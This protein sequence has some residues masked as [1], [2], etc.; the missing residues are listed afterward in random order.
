MKNQKY[1]AKLAATPLLIV[2]VGMGAV[3]LLLGLYHNQTSPPEGSVVD[4]AQPQAKEEFVAENK[5]AES[6]LQ[7]VPEAPNLYVSDKK[8]DE[9]V[10]KEGDKIQVLP[11]RRYAITL[12]PNDPTP[13]QWY[14]DKIS[15][16]FA[17]DSTTGGS[18]VKI[19]VIDTGFALSHEDM[20]SR[21]ATNS[22][23]SGGGKET[24][25]LDDD[26]N[27]KVDDWR[28]WDFAQSDNNPN[29]GSTNPSSSSAA[30][31]TITSGLV[32]ATGNNGIG[33]ASVNWGAKILPVQ[34]LSD[35]G[36]GYTEDVALAIRYAV[37]QGAHIISMSLGT[38]ATDPYVE[39]ALNYA[40]ANNVLVLAAAGN[41]GCNCVL[42][43]ARYPAVIAVGAT[44]STD[45]RASFSSYGSSLDIMAPGS[46]SIRAPAWS[47]GNQTTAY[48]NNIS[49]TSISTPIVA[50]AAGLVKT[51]NPSMTP[52]QL[53]AALVENADKLAG[54]GGQS[55]TDAYGYGRL[56]ARASISNYRWQLVS[57]NHSLS[58]ALMDPGETQTI[59]VI[60]KNTGTA[61]W[62][63]NGSWP[64]KLGVWGSNST[65]HSSWP[66][67]DRA[68]NLLE[69]SVAPG[70]NGTF[71]FTVRGPYGGEFFERMNLVAEGMQW[72]N[73]PG[74]L[75]YLNVRGQFRW[76]EVYH[77]HS[78]NSAVNTAGTTITLTLKAR[79][80]GNITWKKAGDFPVRL[81]TSRPFNRGTNFF[82][83]DSWLSDTR[84]VGL[85]EDSVPPGG[86]GTFTFQAKMHP[87]PGEYF[88]YFNLVADGYSWF[89]DPGANWY[90]RIP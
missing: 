11:R 83:A 53:T 42:Y 62:S 41:D 61:T 45:N 76:E 23:E 15:A 75:Y 36:T 24:N 27:G 79:N 80:T 33:V 43:P 89:N 57:L 18:S 88:E 40:S 10:V 71:V 38:N 9:L 58:T 14:T 72:F 84:P 3:F 50:G 82:V 39:S 69:D 44:D 78:T 22:G 25:G 65:R 13:S 55:R 29:A 31:G 73:D 48:S 52:S 66:S 60:A 34:A 6:S 32:G 30:H 46:G 28:G 16:P 21:W 49:G 4:I 67:P 63:K 5:L 74:F 68:A 8:V 1:P 59:T 37:D 51:L 54:M 81:A 12:T 70:A 47:S 19:A 20:S 85:S 35:S 26:S 64:V 7:A 56:N 87:T 90:V 17:W 2:L 77:T 86:I